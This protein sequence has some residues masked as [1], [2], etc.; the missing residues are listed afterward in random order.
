M[1]Q[2]IFCHC[3]YYP[4]ASHVMRGQTCHNVT[5]GELT[6]VPNIKIKID[7]KTR[8]KKICINHLDHYPI[9]HGLLS[10]QQDLKK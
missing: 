6:I 10:Q 3:W 9:L 4:E 2:T 5:I 1:P 8:D 7:C